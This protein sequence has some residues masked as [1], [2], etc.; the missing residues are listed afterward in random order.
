MDAQSV[1]DIMRRA[2]VSSLSKREKCG[3]VFFLWWLFL[4]ALWEYL[5]A[6]FCGYCCIKYIAR[7]CAVFLWVV[8]MLLDFFLLSS[9]YQKE[10]VGAL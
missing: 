1:D 7:T 3:I 5:F 10:A 6:S 8:V 9:R 4:W 2:E